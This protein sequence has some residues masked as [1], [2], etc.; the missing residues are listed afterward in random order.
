MLIV[1]YIARIA[2]KLKCLKAKFLKKAN[3]VEHIA[4]R[5]AHETYEASLILLKMSKGKHVSKKEVEFLKS[6]SIDVAKALGIIGLQA[7]PFSSIGI[8]AIEVIGK[9][10]GF[11]LF[12]KGQKN[13]ERE[14][15]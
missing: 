12:P 6:Q 3:E 7:I 9:K 14:K 5:E 1:I 15:K 10:H 8:V 11:S 4:K 13:S 2:D